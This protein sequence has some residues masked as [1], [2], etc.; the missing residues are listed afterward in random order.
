M[1]W[2]GLMH[3][4]LVIVVFE[5]TQA[6][7][8]RVEGG[9]CAPGQPAARHRHHGLTLRHRTGQLG[10]V[11]VGNTKHTTLFRVLQQVML[12]LCIG[13]ETISYVLYI[14]TVHNIN[15]SLLLLCNVVPG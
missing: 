9:L 12:V 6:A 8:G 11:L 15:Y 5:C 3:N 4:V 10:F 1:A 14:I 13:L 7:L 2:G